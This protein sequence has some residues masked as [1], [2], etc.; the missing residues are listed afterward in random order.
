[1]THD[2]TQETLLIRSDS[3]IKDYMNAR[4]VTNLHVC[5]LKQGVGVGCKNIIMYVNQSTEG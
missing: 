3:A 5:E 4:L 2:V 1:M